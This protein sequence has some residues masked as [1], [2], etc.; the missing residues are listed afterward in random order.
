MNYYKRH[1]GDYARKTAHLTFLEDAAY[2]RLIDIYYDREAPIPDGEAE[3]LCRAGSAAEK[4]AVRQVLKEF[5]ELRDGCWHHDRCDQ[6]IAKLDAAAESARTNG[7]KGGRPKKETDSV[8]EMKPDG[9]PSG[10]ESET[11]SKATPRLQ[12][13]KTSKS[14]SAAPAIDP[15]KQIFDLG[16][17]ILGSDSRAIIAGAIKRVGETK[18]AEVLGHMAV[19]TKAEPRS[20]FIRSTTE[21]ERQVAL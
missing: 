1:I 12:D 14:G 7:K 8:I 11:G 10:F 2:N 3:R 4:R 20:Y 15:R 18:V 5:F 17:S 21:P 9:N 19:S 16:V 13:S 6:E